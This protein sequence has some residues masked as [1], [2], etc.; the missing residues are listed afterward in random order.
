MTITAVRPEIAVAASHD[1][2]AVRNG[3]LDALRAG[4]T[5]LVVLHHTAITYGGAGG[6]F[7]RELPSSEALSSQLLTML[8]AINQSYFM[9]LFFL[10]AGYFTPAAVERHGVAAFVRERLLRLG[11]PF[12]VFGILIG[13]ATVALVQAV[14]RNRDFGEALLQRWRIG[15]FEPG[16]PG[17]ARHC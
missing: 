1:A 7:Y 10:I 13:P 5:L 12:L 14:T 17:F 2:S 16:R 6:W 11:V 8:C 9:G 3:G 4:L 15:A